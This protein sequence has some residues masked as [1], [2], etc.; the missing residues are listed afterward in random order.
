LPKPEGKKAKTG[1][2]ATTPPAAGKKAKKNKKGGG[3]GKNGGAVGTPTGQAAKPKGVTFSPQL[4]HFSETYSK[5]EYD[6]TPCMGAMAQDYFCDVCGQ[7]IQ[8]IRFH[9]GECDEFDL[10]QSCYVKEG[11][12]HPCGLDSF[13]TPDMIDYEDEGDEGEGDD[14]T[15]E[16]FEAFLKQHNVTLEGF[17]DGMQGGEGDE[18]DEGDEDEGEDQSALRAALGID[19]GDS[20]EEAEEQ[21]EAEAEEEEEEEEAAPAAAP[22]KIVKKKDAGDAKKD[23]KKKKKKKKKG[24][25]K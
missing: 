12:K 21:Q 20:S 17:F 4:C 2:T 16:Q 3:A 14:M 6:R 8:D 25:N 11:N 22:P 19:G 9:C 7:D 10:C 1:S 24:S 23:K 5:Q 15:Q 18:G 13:C